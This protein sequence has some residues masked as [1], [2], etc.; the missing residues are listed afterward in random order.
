MSPTL[1]LVQGLLDDLARDGDLRQPCANLRAAARS[2][3]PALRGRHRLVA[4]RFRAHTLQDRALDQLAYF[5]RAR[6]LEATV[7]LQRGAVVD[8]AREIG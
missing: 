6:K 8:S 4:R 1:H 3:Q 7:A 5:E 2:S